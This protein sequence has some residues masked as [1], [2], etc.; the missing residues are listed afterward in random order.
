MNKMITEYKN[1]PTSVKSFHK[2]IQ[3]KIDNFDVLSFDS[4]DLLELVRNKKEE[5]GKSIDGLGYQRKE[6]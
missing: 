6:W 5:I 3:K 4:T 2:L 1:N